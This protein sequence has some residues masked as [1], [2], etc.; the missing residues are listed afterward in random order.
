MVAGVCVSHATGGSTTDGMIDYA[1]LAHAALGTLS[2]LELIGMAEQ[3]LSYGGTRQDSNF[4]RQ[5][6]YFESRRLSERN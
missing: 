6:H 2:G 1:R 3:S 4:G 5:N